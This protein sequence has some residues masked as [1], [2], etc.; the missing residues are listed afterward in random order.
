MPAFNDVWFR[1]ASAS[2]SA[3]RPMA[4]FFHP[5]DEVGGW[6]LLYGPQGFVQYKF[7]VPPTRAPVIEDAVAAIPSSVSRPFW[8]CWRLC[9]RNAG[10]TLVQPGGWNLALD[11]PLGP[12]RLPALLD[13]LDV[14]GADAGGH[15]YRA[16]D[17]RLRPDLLPAM[18]PGL[19][20]GCGT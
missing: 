15:V 11:F 7:A 18:Y 4:G 14:T 17:V 20:G 9:P 12:P 5:L 6:N 19:K 8:P 16:K 10:L 13:H 1:V 2:E 3:L